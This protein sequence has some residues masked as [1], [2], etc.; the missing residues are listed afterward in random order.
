MNKILQDYIFIFIRYIILVIVALPNFYLFYLIFTPLTIYASYGILNV[1]YNLTLNQNIIQVVGCTS[2]EI[3]PACVAG[4]AY[5]LLLVLNLAI[6]K[7]EIK[8]RLFLFLSSFSMLFL[9]N[10]L[11]ISILSAM[12]INNIASFD[13]IHKVFW[14]AGSTIIVVIIWFLNIKLFNIKGIPFYTDLKFMYQKI[15]GN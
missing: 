5:Y 6:P 11:R 10:V 7:I 12:Y 3:V 14:Y 13:V 2:I 4:V 1:F 8:K 9:I 15:K